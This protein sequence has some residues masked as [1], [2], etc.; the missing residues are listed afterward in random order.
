MAGTAHGDHGFGSITLDE[1]TAEER[2]AAASAADEI[3]RRV[4]E[5][6]GEITILGLAPL[7]NIAR[8]MAINPDLTEQVKGIIFMGGIILGP[9]NVGPFATAN[10]LN[11]LEAAATVY[12]RACGKL[13]MVGQDV[14]RHVRI[15]DDRYKRIGRSGDDG[16][17]LY[18]LSSFY[19][20]FYR[21]SEPHLG[22]FP[23]HDLLV[24]VYALRPDLFWT[25]KLG[26]RIERIGE[27]T[28]GM[29]VAD[30]RAR[31]QW[32]RD[33]TVCRGAEGHAI[34]D[35]YEKALAGSGSR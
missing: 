10:V 20:N 23:V 31:S 35:C 27:H 34:L 30:L 28:K 24:M 32:P 6:P 17:F 22:G 26:V 9:G 13:T 21:G 25:E 5:S 33:V 4:D 29:T 1:P 15:L 14:T 18:Q 3:A 8:A 11:D 2:V 16:K 12:E 7:T 19:R